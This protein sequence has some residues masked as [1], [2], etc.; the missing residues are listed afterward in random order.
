MS[1]LLD[2]NLPPCK[3]AAERKNRILSLLFFFMAFISVQVYAQDIKISGTVIS[4]SDNY[5]II[6]ANILV[7]GTTI[8]TI[9]D[10]DGNFSFEAPKGSTLVVSYIGYQSQEMQVSGNAPIKIVLSEDSEKLDEVIVIGYG[11]QKKSDMTGGIVAVGNEKLQMVST[12]NLMD[13]LAGQV[14]GLNITMEK[15]SPSEDQ[16]LRV[17]G[18]NSLTADNSPLIVLDGIP[19]SGSLGDIDPDNIE[20]L[21]VLKDASSAAI[22]GSRGANGV[23]LIQTKK[24]KKGTATVSYKGQ[25]G[26]SQPERRVDVM[27]GPEYVKFL[28]DQWAYMNYNGVIKNPEDILNVSEIENWRNGIETDWQDQIFRT[29]LTN[30]HQLSVS[31][32]T[33]KTTYMASIS[34]LNQ[35]GVVKDTG[36][37]RTNIALNITQQLG[38]WL[39]IGMATQAV[40]KEYGGIQAGISD[41]LCQ[42]PYGQPYNSDGSLNFYPMDQ[43]LHANP[44]ADLEATSDKTDRNIFISTYADAKLPIKGLSFRTNFG[45]NYRSKFEGSYY[46]RNTV[47]GKA[48]NGSAAIKNQ[49]DWDYTWENVLKYELQLGK[50]KFDATGLFSMQQTSQEISEQKGTSFVNDDS[51]YHNMAGAEE[52]KTVTSELTET[53]MLSYML[54]LNYNYANRYLFTATGRSDGY[55]A[56]GTNNKYAFFPSL[57]AAWNISSEEFM[58]STNNWMDMLKIRLSW[59]SNGNQAIKAYQTL[60]RL[61]LTNYIWG[62]KGTTVNGVILSYNSIGNPNLKW[63]TTRTVNAGVD[64]SFFNSRLSGSVDFYVSNTSDLLMS[65]TVPIMNGYNSIMDNVG[66]TRNTGIELALNSVNMENKDFRW[67]TS[68]NFSL[69]RDKIIE[70]RG[71]GKDDITNKWFIGEPV[72]VYYDYNV[73]GTWQEDDNFLNAD[74]KEIQ[75]GAKPG[76]AKLED[77]DGDGTITAKDKKIIGSKLPSFT[78]SLGNTFTYK[79]F[80]FSF[81]LNGV[82]GAWKEMID[83]NFDRWSSKYNYISG[84]DYWTPENPTNAMTSPGY[85]PY[86]K[87]SFYK[88]MNYVR[89]KN[90][91]LGYNIPKA[92]LTPVGISA[93]NVNLSVNN[94]Y[95]FSNVKNALNFDGTD[96]NANIVSCYPTARSFMLGLN[97][98]F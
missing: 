21:S 5:P 62:D 53:A 55:S 27:K 51:E 41:A 65:R 68:Y 59:G 18:E 72:K 97:L 19:Y 32:G 30:S 46:G 85:V 92:I 73:V 58:E 67:S 50:H 15:A 98:I 47:T 16:V 56:F 22:Y 40:Q 38:N 64:F 90:I 17:R 11:S 29:A 60:D 63:E 10:V 23:I 2:G 3:K 57:A 13:K 70:L 12:N 80:T 95:T 31:G 89:I 71:D 14:P 25:V 48:K 78:M 9:T 82:F 35:E 49:H 93:L 26:F 8:G 87:H 36:M 77:V 6:G 69:N 1:R 66:E 75:K 43:T 88:K 76:H 44:L 33:E 28:Q 83:Y 61:K 86:D 91:T 7:K 45:Y 4:G 39:T 54:R 42:S 79:D 84:M 52:N 74:G 20:N 81:L 37:K 24:G 96:Y 94:L 34:R